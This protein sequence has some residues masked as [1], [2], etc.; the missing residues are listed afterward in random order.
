M[1]TKKFLTL[2]LGLVLVFS[3]TAYT[4]MANDNAMSKGNETMSTMDNKCECG[5]A[6]KCE[7]DATAA[8]GGDC[9]DMYEEPQ[10]VEEALALHKKLMAQENAILSQNTEL[11]EKVYM[12]A[13]KGMAL[14]EDGKNYGEFLMDT[15]EAAKDQFTD[16]EYETLKQAAAQISEIEKRLTM[17]EEKYP[18][19]AQMSLDS[20]MNMPAD[21]AMS[22]TP[23]DGSMQ[24]F[25]AFEG[26]DLDGNDGEERASCSRATP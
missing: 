24:K 20:D 21:G 23:D 25:P 11:W 7:C 5:M 1:K 16:E 14:V 19:A 4:A 6:D 26:K 17:L 22:M 12:E 8:C 2:L 15:I 9:S 18:E 10:S 3:M 13:D